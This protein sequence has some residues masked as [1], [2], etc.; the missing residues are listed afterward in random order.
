MPINIPQGGIVA[1]IYAEEG[2]IVKAGDPLVRFDNPDFEQGLDEKAL[3]ISEQLNRNSDSRLSLEQNLRQMKNQLIDAE[4]SVKRQ[5][6][7]LKRSESLFAKQLISKDAIETLRDDLELQEKKH[8]Q[9]LQDMKHEENRYPTKMA[10]LKKSDERANKQLTNTE[11]SMDKLTTRAPIS[12]QVIDMEIEL[13]ENK[14][15]GAL[16]RIDNIETYILSA[17]APEHYINRIRVGQLASFTYDNNSYQAEVSKVFPTV[18]NGNFKIRLKFHEAQPENL[19]RGLTIN[20]RLE[21][22]A[23]S[24]SLLLDNGSFMQDTGGNWAFVLSPDGTSATRRDISLGRRNKDVAEVH[25]GLK[26]GDK[27]IISSYEGLDEID[28]VILTK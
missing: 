17:E 24:D 27:V 8:E 12:G 2:D 15:A 16:G 19:R 6:R 14:A 18:E 20:A 3:N 1:K 21:L 22:S 23:A 9:L 28:K 4:Y 11:R 13:G 25:T 7:E 10:E 5:K 26:E